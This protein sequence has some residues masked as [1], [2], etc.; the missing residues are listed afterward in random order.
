MRTLREILEM[1]DTGVNAILN[2][3][4]L[5]KEEFIEKYADEELYNALKNAKTGLIEIS[6]LDN[7]NKH[8]GFT[9]AFGEG[10][11]CRMSN[12]DNWYTTTT[13]KSI[14]WDNKTFETR[15]SVYKFKFQEIPI[16]KALASAKE[17]YNKLENESKNKETE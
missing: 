11:A 7:T 13:I 9:A 14:D 6:Y 1:L 3:K 2:C 4:L 8:Y 10:L 16:D 5:S 15:N 17:L 12:E